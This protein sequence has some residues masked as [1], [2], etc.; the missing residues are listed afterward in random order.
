MEQK[1]V[2]GKTSKTCTT[3]I[4]GVRK[5]EQQHNKVCGENA[6]AIHTREKANKTGDKTQKILHRDRTKQKPC[7]STEIVAHFYF[8]FFI[9]FFRKTKVVQSSFCLVFSCGSLFPSILELSCGQQLI[10]CIIIADKLWWEYKIKV[11]T[12]WSLFSPNIN[13]MNFSSQPYSV[14][15]LVLSSLFL[16]AW[17]DCLIQ[18]Y[19]ILN[20]QTFPRH[21]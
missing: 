19:I 17:C 18:Q 16:T 15:P 8:I 3:C 14:T 11:H 12:V 10:K 21:M 9:I 1:C 7:S 5:R 2:R 6:Q 4:S 20:S 13:L